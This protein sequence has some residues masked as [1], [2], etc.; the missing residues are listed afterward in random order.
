MDP[1]A[2]PLL[3][4]DKERFEMTEVVEATIGSGK[5][6]G[7]F[8]IREFWRDIG[9]LADYERTNEDHATHFAAP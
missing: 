7:A 4:A 6:V 9:Q 8:P 1:A 5:R 3:P 2:V